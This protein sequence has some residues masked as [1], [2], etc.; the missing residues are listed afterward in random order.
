M[1]SHTGTCTAPPPVYT[2]QRPELL[3]SAWRKSCAYHTKRP[4]WQATGLV[5]GDKFWGY[6]RSRLGD[7]TILGTFLD[8]KYFFPKTLFFHETL[9]NI[10]NTRLKPFYIQV[11]KK[12]D[13]N[14]RV[15]SQRQRVWEKY[16][17]LRSKLAPGHR[18][19]SVSENLRDLE[20]TKWRLCRLT[21]NGFLVLYFS[22]TRRCNLITEK[23]CTLCLSRSETDF[24]L[25]YKIM[26]EIFLRGPYFYF[27]SSFTP[28]NPA[29]ALRCQNT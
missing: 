14:H 26:F 8:Q 18:L 6:L 2:R 22:H 3:P 9:R 7:S 12:I 24:F 23:Y 1:T 11:R 25:Y 5:K 15:A 16:A 4:R 21:W 20:A 17:I 19:K 27:S 29:C 28:L 13:R 10:I